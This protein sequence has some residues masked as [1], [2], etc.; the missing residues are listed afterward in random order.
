MEANP[1]VD[2]FLMNRQTDAPEEVLAGLSFGVYEYDHTGK[3]IK[4]VFRD[5]DTDQ[6]GEYMDV[7]LRILGADSM[8]QA[9]SWAAADG[10]RETE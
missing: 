8:E 3:Y 4:D 10:G 7:M 6:A 2:A 9:L 1:Y 5:I